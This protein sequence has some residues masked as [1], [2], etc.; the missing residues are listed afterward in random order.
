MKNIK[1]IVWSK[2]ILN[3]EKEYVFFVVNYFEILNEFVIRKMVNYV[4]MIFLNKKVFDFYEG[5]LIYL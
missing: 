1:I 2:I 4:C 5:L 3:V